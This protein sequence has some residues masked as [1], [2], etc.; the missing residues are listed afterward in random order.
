MDQHSFA[1]TGYRAPTAH[2]RSSSSSFSISTLSYRCELPESN[3]RDALEDDTDLHTE[4]PA[5]W[6]RF[7]SHSPSSPSLD[8]EVD[9]RSLYEDCSPSPPQF[10]ALQLHPTSRYDKFSNN[11]NHTSNNSNNNISSSAYASAFDRDSSYNHRQLH[12]QSFS[13]RSSPRVAAVD[14]LVNDTPE[15][16]VLYLTEEYKALAEPMSAWIADYLVK[17]LSYPE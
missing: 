3:V 6:S 9:A 14:E 10:S 15:P 8:A 16:P 12:S 5:S 2:S 1:W 7:V 11:S 17:V 4:A 13:P